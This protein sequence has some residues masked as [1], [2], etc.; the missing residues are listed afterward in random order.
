MKLFMIIPLFLVV[1]IAVWE[2]TLAQ[3]TNTNGV[4]DTGSHHV[5]K[6]SVHVQTGQHKARSGVRRDS[7]CYN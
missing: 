4:L 2:Q 1:T 6:V 7:L 3:N 5:M